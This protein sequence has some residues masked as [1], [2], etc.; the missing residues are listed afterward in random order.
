M[1]LLYA[2]A[3]FQGVKQYPVLE[4]SSLQKLGRQHLH[5]AL[6]V[7]CWMDTFLGD[8]KAAFLMVLLLDRHSARP[9]SF[10]VLEAWNRICDIFGGNSS[11]LI[12]NTPGCSPYEF[13]HI[14][15]QFE[16]SKTV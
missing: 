6:E 5:D 3:S 15:E 1:P 11:L 4:E 7:L 12:L 14:L 10:G 13:L 9:L 16:M 2:P 8:P